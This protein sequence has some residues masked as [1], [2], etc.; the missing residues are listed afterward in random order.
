MSGQELFDNI[1]RHLIEDI[2]PSGY[3]NDI[4]DE[5]AFR[6]HPFDMLRKMRR[7]EQSPV[8]HPEGNVWN[9]TLL[10]V[11]EAAK[12]KAQSSDMSA[13]MWAALLHDTG[14]PSV[15]KIRKNRITAYDHDRIGARLAGEFL[16][17][18]VKDEDFIAKVVGLVRYHMHVFYIVK[19]LPFADIQGMKKSTDIKE[20]ALLGLCDRLG[21]T[22]PN[23]EEEK[24]NIMMF[25]KLCSHI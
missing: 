17:I 11:D 7:T 24:K 3:L 18:Y 15:T 20:L 9:H 1:G 16:S 6:Q 5:P 23:V 22:K 21:R 13:F 25:L 2:K 12:V 10:V 19:E 8:H 14:K 4:Y